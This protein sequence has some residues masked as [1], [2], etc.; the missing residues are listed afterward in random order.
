MAGAP[1]ENYNPARNFEAGGGARISADDYVEATPELMVEVAASTISY[2]LHEKFRI[3]RR[4]GVQEYIVWR[5]DDQE[6]NWFHLA[7]Q[8]YV[9][10][11]PDAKGIIHSRVFPGLQLDV[12]AL[13]TGNMKKV[14][15][16]LRSGLATP[17]HAAF[18]KK[19]AAARRTQQRKSRKVAPPKKSH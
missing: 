7:G 16:V 11:A 14:L 6:I 9:R 2:D 3:Y 1:H 19:L 5:V 12:N 18:V 8:Q 17:E 15:T 4:N 13:L 10:V